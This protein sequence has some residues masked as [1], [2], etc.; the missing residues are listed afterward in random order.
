MI[1]DLELLIKDVF[2]SDSKVSELIM[3]ARHLLKDS[4]DD[5]FLEWLKNEAEGYSKDGEVPKY[6]IIEGEPKGWNPVNGWIPFIHSNSDIQTKL[7]KRGVNQSIFEIESLLSDSDKTSFEIPYPQSLQS[8]LG[9]SVDFNTKFTLVVPEVYLHKI[10]NAVR[11]GLSSHLA[12]LDVKKGASMSTSSNIFPQ[13]I[14]EKLPQDVAVLA[15]DFNFNYSNNRLI[16][17]MLILRRIVPLCIVRKFQSIDRESEIRLTNGEFMDTKELLGK[18]ESLLS[19]KK[20]Y[21]GLIAYKS[22]ID[23]AQHSYSFQSYVDDVE[24][25]AIKIRLLL[26]NIY[27]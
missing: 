24:G 23:S 20:I 6:R 22:I 13:E 26:E 2:N 5:V 18:I 12:K 27:T 15:E 8:E 17:S 4:E 10:L 7:S 14:L 25:A 3:R 19:E 16:A 1:T 21:S 9:E 11:S